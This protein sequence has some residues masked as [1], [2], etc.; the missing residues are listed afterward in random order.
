MEMYKMGRFVVVL[1]VAAISSGCSIKQIQQEREELVLENSEL[2]QQMESIRN[3][4]DTAYLQRKEMENKAAQLKSELDNRTANPPLAMAFDTNTPTGF[5]G[6]PNVEA[7]RQSGRVTVH[8]PGDILFDAGK[9]NLKSTAR[10]TLDQ[11]ARVLR[12]EYR[13]RMI[14]VAGHTD[15][16]PIHKSKWKDNLELSLQRAA[17][18]HRQLQ[19]QGIAP[20]QLV[21]AGY[22]PW[23][24]RHSKAKSRRVEIVVE[25]N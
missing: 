11:I 19:S 7:R 24:S 12:N 21:A 14:H 5:E 13:G 17:T 4:L 23:H 3:D 15:R 9:A 20:K 6:I 22:G 2:R 8:V 16:D 25:L 1:L 10:K 18:V